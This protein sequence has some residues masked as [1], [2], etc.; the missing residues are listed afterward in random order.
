MATTAKTAGKQDKKAPSAPNNKAC[1]Y[2]EVDCHNP[3]SHRA[4]YHASAE[5]SVLVL[6]AD[7]WHGPVWQSVKAPQALYGRVMH[8]MASTFLPV[9]Y[10]HVRVLWK[11]GGWCGWM[12]WD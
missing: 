11:C 6:A 10:P 12:G 3:R 8:A 2:T 9:G 4:D 1:C 5:G 7:A